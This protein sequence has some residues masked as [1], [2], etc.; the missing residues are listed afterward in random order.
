[1]GAE[2]TEVQPI[3][4]AV[5]GPPSVTNPNDG[6]ESWHDVMTVTRQLL[7]R[8]GALRAGSSGIDRP[9]ATEGTP[10]ARWLR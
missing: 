3:A 10:A 1:M 8:L 7:N 4:A 9:L 6:E 2:F 5:V